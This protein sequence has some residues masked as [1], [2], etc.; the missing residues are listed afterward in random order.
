MFSF[1]SDECQVLEKD[2]RVMLNKFINSEL[3]KHSVIR[4]YGAAFL[5]MVT[6]GNITITGLDSMQLDTTYQTSCEEEGRVVRFTATSAREV[7]MTIPWALCENY[8]G[9]VSIS[10]GLSRFEGAILV[11]RNVDGFPVLELACFLPTLA[12]R[13]IPQLQGA[14]DT[15]RTTVGVL[16]HL[17]PGP[18]REAWLETVTGHVRQILMDG[19]ATL[20]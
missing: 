13:I 4:V 6:V 16:G 15:V 20:Q 7:A 9:N 2:V 18:L 11:T 1:S 3:P 5:P 10:A 14:G 19:L 8:T 12:E 17:F